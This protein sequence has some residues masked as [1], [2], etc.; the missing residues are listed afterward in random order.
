MN[1]FEAVRI[2]RPVGILIAGAVLADI[3]VRSQSSSFLRRSL[4]N[5][6]TWLAVVL[7]FI[8]FALSI[9]RHPSPTESP[10]WLALQFLVAI[11]LIT[12]VV[13]RNSQR[14]RLLALAGTAL[15][16][17]LVL[18]A[19]ITIFSYESP[20]IGLTLGATALLLVAVAVVPLVPQFHLSKWVL[21]PAMA[22]LVLG[23]LAFTIVH[24][25]DTVTLHGTGSG[26]LSLAAA[27]ALSRSDPRIISVIRGGVVTA[28]LGREDRPLE[29]AITGDIAVS[30]PNYDQDVR[31]RL[32]L[33]LGYSH[34]QHLILLAEGV[35]APNGSLQLDYS[36]ALLSIR[37][38][39]IFARGHIT[40]AIS[41]AIFGTL[42]L[43]HREYSMLLTYS[44]I[45]PTTVHGSL[46]IWPSRIPAGQVATLF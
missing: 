5:I 30:K 8:P 24:Q 31:L 20:V 11:I 41:D 7:I 14:I 32:S 18:H 9:V 17:V 21:G 34:T 39:R 3:S 15:W 4:R 12:G 10:I 44:T 16:L 42:I 37:S 27:S 1:Y 23:G 25:S 36:R 33:D 46:T 35:P 6:G 22:V 38:L 19:T 29:F 43:R 2:A 26:P 40:T 28:G 45:T 13:D